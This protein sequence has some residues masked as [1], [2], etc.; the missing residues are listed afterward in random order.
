VKE[1]TLLQELFDAQAE[2]TWTAVAAGF[3]LH[4]DRRTAVAKLVNML[5]LHI[6]DGGPIVDQLDVDQRSDYDAIARLLVQ[7]AGTPSLT[8]DRVEEEALAA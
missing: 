6:H 2:R 3:L 5:Q 1:T 7:A 8:K 4:N